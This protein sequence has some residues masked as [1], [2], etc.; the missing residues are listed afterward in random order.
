VFWIA[1]KMLV[2]KRGKYVGMVLGIVF[3]ALLIGQQSGVFCGAMWLTTGQIPDVQDADIWV[4]D[5]NVAYI[6]DIKPLRETD[7]HRVRGAS[8]IG[9]ALCL[10][11]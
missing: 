5:G 10:Y 7:L 6:D 11:E 4:K 8:G 2:G 3:A 1:F 9:W